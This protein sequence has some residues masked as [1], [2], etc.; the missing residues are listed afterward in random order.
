MDIRPD[1]R[2]AGER[3]AATST[4]RASLGSF[5]FVAPRQQPH[6]RAELGLHIQHPLT[7]KVTDR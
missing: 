3:S 2:R 6:P 5:L 7:R 4:G 1:L